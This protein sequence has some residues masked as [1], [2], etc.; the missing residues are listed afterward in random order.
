MRGDSPS[1]LPSPRE[2]RGEGEESSLLWAHLLDFG[3]ARK[4]I[5]TLAVGGIDHDALAVLQ[6]SL[7]GEG[8]E[9]RLVVDLAEGDLAERRRHRDALGRRDQLL[10]IGR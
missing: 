2:E 9:R 10:W 7:A 6:R 3:V 5:R 1:P 8:A 4:I